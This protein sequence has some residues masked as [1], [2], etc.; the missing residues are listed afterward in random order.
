M[1]HAK[2]VLGYPRTRAGIWAMPTDELYN[3]MAE[4][5]AE[6]ADWNGCFACF[7][8]L[9][10]QYRDDPEDAQLI[11]LVRQYHPEGLADNITNPARIV[12][13]MGQ[14]FVHVD[15]P[16]VYWVAF[17]TPGIDTVSIGRISYMQ[18][19]PQ[20][21]IDARRWVPLQEER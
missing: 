21:G 9:V 8:F 2:I 16:G 17:K 7:A 4:C 13:M 1:S 15:E 11:A 18:A 20:T 19:I 6:P 12:P 5:H 10:Y 14:R 3:M